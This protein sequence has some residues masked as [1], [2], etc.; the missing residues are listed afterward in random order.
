[1]RKENETRLNLCA[2]AQKVLRISEEFRL[3]FRGTRVI[4][5]FLSHGAVIEIRAGRRK[6]LLG[7]GLVTWAEL[8]ENDDEG[9]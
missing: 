2:T 1:M 5:T 4:M 7:G 6:K 3:R 9:G 8:E